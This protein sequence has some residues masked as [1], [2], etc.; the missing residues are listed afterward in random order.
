MVANK[1]QENYPLLHHLCVCV[2]MAWFSV[3][4][5]NANGVAHLEYID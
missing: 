1:L 5:S 3:C 4:H 2:H